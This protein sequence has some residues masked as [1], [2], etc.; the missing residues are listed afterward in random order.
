MIRNKISIKIYF[1]FTLLIFIN[2]TE[3][4][5][6]NEKNENKQFI[7]SNISTNSNSNQYIVPH[8]T[9]APEWELQHRT[10]IPLDHM[11]HVTPRVEHIINNCPCAVAVRCEPCGIAAPLGPNWMSHV[12]CPCAARLNCPVCPPLSII[13]E[14]A[15]K[16]VINKF[17]IGGT[18]SKISI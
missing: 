13:H 8:I 14:I 4:K 6:N 2:S 15:A 3:D 17:Q 1:I 16:K 9:K 10:L 5:S 18:R 12:D 7:N 11:D